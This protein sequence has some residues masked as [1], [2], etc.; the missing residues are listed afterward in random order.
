MSLYVPDEPISTEMEDGVHST[1]CH[2]W[3]TR[4]KKYVAR[5]VTV[6]N[7]FIVKTEYLYDFNDLGKLV[8]NK[9]EKSK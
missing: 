4:D 5:K 8:R 2:P 9:I 6:K 7:G 1:L 3:M